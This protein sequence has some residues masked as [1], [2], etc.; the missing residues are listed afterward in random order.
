[1]LPKPP[2]RSHSPSP[3]L[4]A[5]FA[6]KS[7]SYIGVAFVATIVL[8]HILLLQQYERVLTTH[9]E[10]GSVVN[11]LANRRSVKSLSAKASLE[12]AD[13]SWPIKEEPDG[14]K[15]AWLMSFPNSG[16][17]FTSRLVR[18]ATKTDSASN[19]ADETPSGL[20]GLRL[21]VYDDL[22]EGPFWIK[23]EASPEFTEPTEYV[24]TKT[25]C[26]IRCTMCPPEK[27]AEST[28]SFR[29]NCLKTK[30]VEVNE[31]EGTS[32]RVFSTYPPDRLTRAIHLIR[33]PFDNV[34]SRY[35]LERQL[36][37]REAAKYPKTRKGFR[38]YCKS[39][40][41]LHKANEKR[42]LFLDE[43]LLEVMQVVPCHADF[44]RYIEWHNLAFVTTRDLQLHTYVLHYDW[45]TTRFNE[46]ARELLEFLKLP[47]HKNGDLTPFIE[48]KVYP[49]Y[50]NEEKRAVARAFEIMS[51]PET[52]KHVQH[53]FDDAQNHVGEE[54][55]EAVPVVQKSNRPPLSSLVKAGSKTEITGDVQFLLDF[56]IV[57]YPKTATSTKVRWLASQKQIQM[58]NHEIYHL[59]D[60]EPADMVRK[61]YALPEGDHYKRGYK[62]PRDI[63]N[64][65]AVNSFSKYFPTTK[66]IIGLRHPVL[67]FESFYNYRTRNNITLPHTSKLIGDCSADAY[68]VCT[69]EIRYMDHLSAMGKTDRTNPE[70]L[71]LLSPVLPR[72]RQSQPKLNNEVFLYEISQI[73][74]ADETLAAQYRKDLQEYLGLAE[75]IEPLEETP[76]SH[77][78][79]PVKH[80][81]INICDE[82]HAAVHTDLMSIARMSSQWIRKYFLP[83]PHVHVSSPEHFN[84]LIES[85]M[86]DP[87][88]ARNNIA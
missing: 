39:I 38:A 31:T 60:G 18:D 25:H 22:P 47:I 37:G 11:S 75:P 44:F 63:H 64:V 21:P 86:I 49:Y 82:E 72:H 52:W 66:F 10:V 20:A 84:A 26:G 53:Y 51:S 58:Y 13:F 57:G 67:W 79:S 2:R 3:T 81:E 28:Y 23:P 17:S 74:E 59:K 27:Y 50:T 4:S 61:L 71:K 12:S 30:W 65:R 85:W 87:C 46:T 7:A 88:I 36:P 29:R 35:H 19:Y 45:Y 62:A 54:E 42:I 70:E 73:E 24:I 55:E 5:V 32:E 83:L 43:D 15:V 40:D 68:N 16:T 56:A 41:N 77:E 78:T 48:G 80:L 6:P 34:V 14:L 8:A 69:E 1:M 76:E 9:H 33:D